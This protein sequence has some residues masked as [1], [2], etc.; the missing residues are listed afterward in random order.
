MM[1]PTENFMD[2]HSTFMPRHSQTIEQAATSALFLKFPD[3]HFHV[4]PALDSVYIATTCRFR[5]YFFFCRDFAVPLTHPL[6]DPS[7]P[8]IVMPLYMAYPF[9]PLAAAAAPAT[10]PASPP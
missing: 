4:D 1:N 10:L 7:A 2:S 5:F 8:F 6:F 9:P 3:L